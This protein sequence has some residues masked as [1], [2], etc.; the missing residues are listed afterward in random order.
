MNDSALPTRYETW[1]AQLA[2]PAWR[3]RKQ[4]TTALRELVELDADAPEVLSVVAET[5]LEGLISQ[6]AINGRASCHEVL[7]AIGKPA[8]PGLL[9]RLDEPG[10]GQRLLVDL[11]GDIGDATHASRLATLVIDAMGDTNLRGAAAVALGKI[12]GTHAAAALTSLLEDPVAM[13]RMHALEAMRSG[14]VPLEPEK[15]V[16][17]LEDPYTRKAAAAVIGN[18]AAVG[19]AMLLGPLL[20]D[21]TIGV[22][23]T[24]VVSLVRIDERLNHPPEIEVMLRAL[25]AATLARVR[26]LVAQSSPEVRIAAMRLAARAG[27][28]DV[29]GH[30]FAVMD[31]P[32]LSEQALA[33]VRALGAAAASPTLA[34]MPGLPA[35]HHVHLFR[36][37][38]ALPTPVD[39]RLLVVL[40]EGLHAEPSEDGM[41]AAAEALER[42]G[43]QDC[44]AELYRAMECSGRIGEAAAD[45]VVAILNREDAGDMFD[46]IIGRYWPQE[47]HLAANLC[48]VV[49]ELRSQ[50]HAGQ[51]VALLGAAEV[52][53]RIAAATALG[54][55]EGDHE[56]A[57]ALSF[58][59]TDEEPQVRAAACRSLGQLRAPRSVHSL[60][61]ATEDRSPMVRA[62]AVH[63]LVALDN[64]VSLARL[65]AVIVEDPVPSVVV[66]AI[67]GLGN[68]GLEQDLT[69]L[70]SL[71]TSEDWEVVKAAARALR[72][73]GEHRATA[74]L[75]GLLSHPRWDVRWAAAEVL[76]QRVDRTALQP[77][78]N[79]LPDEKDRVVRK[80]IRDAIAHLES[81]T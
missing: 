17:L 29:V 71:C 31:E 22:R 74:A 79:A 50:S 1:V 43:T 28:A 76:A 40:T 27:D 41:V 78:R 3:E 11:L 42:V 47:S 72:E 49:G 34:A 58:A 10:M 67:A 20:D 8:I 37:I 33:T 23:Q 2:A 69:M 4:A 59:L 15:G 63:A 25:P 51:L 30:L 64:P 60:L 7:V 52:S 12:G 61:S 75:L 55:L 6:D 36:I 66:Q 38:G 62:A 54:Q 68:S 73:F 53:V 56:G 80:V 46:R 45:A 9:A 44:L 18:T 57:S 32:V 77:L 26:E 70:M 13:L 65:R 35:Q 14:G 48:R 19:A 21:P 16:R 81:E 5:L 24:A 39:A